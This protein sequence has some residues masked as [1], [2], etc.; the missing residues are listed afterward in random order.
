M[1]ILPQ[2]PVT[3]LEQLAGIAIALEGDLAQRFGALAEAQRDRG[4][5]EAA[6]LFERLASRARARRGMIETRMQERGLEILP[7]DLTDLALVGDDETKFGADE[8]LSRL[9]VYRA[10]ALAVRFE[11]RAFRFHSYV[12]AHAIEASVQNAAEALAREA[13]GLAAGLRVERRQAFHAERQ[14]GIGPPVP[15]AR[16]VSS[17]A[18]LLTAAKA[19]ERALSERLAEHTEAGRLSEQTAEV[20]AELG[21][22]AETAG[23]PSPD[24]A[25]AVETWSR[26]QGR[27]DWRG[28]IHE[29][30]QEVLDQAFT[31][32]NAVVERA[33]NE[34]ILTA[35]QML[36][37]RCL[38]RLK[39]LGSEA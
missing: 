8:A 39:S 17:L 21:R 9:T 28:S 33:A 4:E 36:S 3:S 32:Y 26:A 34:E 13:L 30:A 23:Q 31:F 7:S 11:E 38:E 6:E 1:E 2:G 25:A 16:L 20:M 14:A 35:A 10:L 27:R 37:Q 24:L 29:N 5:A 18:D 19:L 15:D 12:A 22:M